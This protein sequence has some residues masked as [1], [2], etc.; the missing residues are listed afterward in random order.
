MRNFVQKLAAGVPALAILAGGTVGGGGAAQAGSGGEPQQALS[1]NVAETA[2]NVEIQL[3][4]LSSVTQ[5]IEYE[6]ELIGNSRARHSGNTSIPA[7][8]R[9][10]LSRLTTNVTGTWCARVNVTEASGEQYTL[11]AG[12]CE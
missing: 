6:I 11:T 12:E 1:L 4:A 9:Q 5:Q 8:D 10:V 7:G 3:I 2:G